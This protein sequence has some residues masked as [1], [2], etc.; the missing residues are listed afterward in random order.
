MTLKPKKS[1]SETT[2]TEPTNAAISE[3]LLEEMMGYYRARAPE[4]NEWW[5]RQGRYDR[6]AK[7]NAQWFAEIQA[8]L[9]D[10]EAFALA[11]DVLE[12]APGTGN[13]TERLLTTASTV[14]AVDAAPEMIAINRERVQSDRVTYILAD[15][16]AWQ[17]PREYDAIFF[18]FWLS[19]VPLER[20][21]T[22]LQK[23]SK[24][25]RKGGK[26]FFIDSL[27]QESS[28][29][30]AANQ[31]DRARNAQIMTRELKDGRTFTIVKNYFDP[32]ALAEQYRA[33]G[34]DVTIKTTPNHFLYGL[35]SKL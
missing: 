2:M 12:L 10:F 1:K 32:A 3:K 19:H 23:V 35:G 33:T 7:N 27:N 11:G 8:V 17:S 4:Y 18:G 24:A 22:F 21:D 5:L 31:P 13:W 26:L 6:G 25:L 9:A 15:L 20:M 16:F 29:G 30:I 34:L 14:T 28:P